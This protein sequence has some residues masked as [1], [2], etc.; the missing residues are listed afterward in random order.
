MKQ[1]FINAVS[2]IALAIVML[3]A[4]FAISRANAGERHGDTINIHNTYIKD[5]RFMEGLGK[6]AAAVIGTQ[7]VTWPATKAYLWPATIGLFTWSRPQWKQW[8]SCWEG[9]K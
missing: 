9:S 3:C 6:G 8:E 4:V 1:K 5:D 7:C 2:M